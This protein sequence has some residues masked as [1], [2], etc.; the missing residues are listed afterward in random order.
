M[1]APQAPLTWL[2]GSRS[3][4]AGAGSPG[5]G[6]CRPGGVTVDGHRLAPPGSGGGERVVAEL[7]QDVA[8]LANEPAGLRQGGDLAVLAVLHGRVVV[9]AGGRRAAVG[10]AGLIGHPAQDLR[11][12]AGPVPGPPLP[13]PRLHR[14][15]Q[16]PQPDPPPPRGKPAP[17]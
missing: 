8:G 10:L 9:V 5:C 4:A 3:W 6:G 15:L 13:P 12:L 7:G 14:A 11:A 1:A 17:P 16:P 2:S